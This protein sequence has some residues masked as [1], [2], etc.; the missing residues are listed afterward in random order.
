M[1]AVRCTKGSNKT[2]QDGGAARKEAV[3][4]PQDMKESISTFKASGKKDI[5]SDETSD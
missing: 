5:W 3:A 2:S 1:A 4:M